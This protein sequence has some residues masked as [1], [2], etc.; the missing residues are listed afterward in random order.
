MCVIIKVRTFFPILLSKWSGF[1]HHVGNIIDGLCVEIER[2]KKGKLRKKGKK[3]TNQMKKE[4]RKKERKILLK[5]QVYLYKV[6][7]RF[8]V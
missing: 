1:Q 3:V 2:K 6:Y 8:Y 5:L 4:L 7:K